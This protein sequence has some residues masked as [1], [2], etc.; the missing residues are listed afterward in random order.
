MPCGSWQL[1]L[2]PGALLQNWEAGRQVSCRWWDPVAA[3]SLE[4]TLYLPCITEGRCSAPAQTPSPA[5]SFKSVP[6]LYPHPEASGLHYFSSS[7]RPLSSPYQSGLSGNQI[8]SQCSSAKRQPVKAYGVD[9]PSPGAALA[10]NPASSVDPALSRPRPSNPNTP[11]HQISC[12]LLPEHF[13][14][15]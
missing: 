11:A 4:G 8:V 7:H 14:Y 15:S 12:P 5:I 13:M 2:G 10:M 6:A 9:S 1:F 3:K